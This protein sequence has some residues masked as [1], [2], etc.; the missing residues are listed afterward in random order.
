MNKAFVSYERMTMIKNQLYKRAWAFYLFI[1]MRVSEKEKKR[2]KKELETSCEHTTVFVNA[3][4]IYTRT[5][6]AAALV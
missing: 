3:M 6:R 5:K 2:E 1:E 4:C